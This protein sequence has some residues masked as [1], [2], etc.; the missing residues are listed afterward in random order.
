M[1]KLLICILFSF[2]VILYGQQ[3]INVGSSPN[4]KTG[5]PLRTAFQKVN[6]NLSAIYD[7][8]GNKAPLTGKARGLTVGGVSWIIRQ[9]L[10]FFKI[11]NLEDEPM[12]V[13]NYYGGTGFYIY[14]G[15]GTY[16]RNYLD[17]TYLET[18]TV[19]FINGDLG[20]T[21]GRLGKGWFTDL[22]VTNAIAGSITGNAATVTGFTRGTYSNSLAL[23]TLGGDAYTLTLT[24][25]GADQNITMPNTSAGT[26]AVISEAQTFTGTQTF[27]STISG[28]ISGNAGT[29]T[30]YTPASGSLTLSGA[31]AVTLTTTAATSVTLPTSGT[32]TNTNDV[33]EQVRDTITDILEEAPIAISRPDSGLITSG[34]YVSGYDWN[35]GIESNV[36]KAAKRV[37]TVDPVLAYPIA[38]VGG[39][40][41]GQTT[42]TDGRAQYITFNIPE[43]ITITGVRF[44]LQTQGNY[45]A[46]EYNGAKLYQVTS[47]ATFVRLDSTSNN[48]DFW[49]GSPVTKNDFAFVG[50]A[51]TL[52]PGLYVVGFIWSASAT[53]AAPVMYSSFNNSS[54]T[55]VM[56]FGDGGANQTKLA[57][58]LSTQTDLA[59]SEAFNDLTSDT[60]SWGIFLY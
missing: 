51:R 44:V 3:L 6:T 2:S 11:Y 48:G 60:V 7:S 55:N 1:K 36:I 9:P 29:V 13:Q 18:G 58:Y 28:N 17:T 50:G 38:C 8:L 4:D 30:G 33:S 35:N 59:M 16:L 34:G 12:D 40:L 32:L 39:I 37:T 57:G 22:E 52:E 15:T 5:D 10:S 20:Y 24:M 21:T 31:D 53:T 45:T 54:A 26:L 47:A 25:R 27:S 43:P 42:M 23:A 49:K 41:T 19:K 56:Y 46:D 14:P